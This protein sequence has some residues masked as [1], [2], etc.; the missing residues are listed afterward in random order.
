MAITA[1]PLVISGVVDMVVDVV[2]VVVHF[3]ERAPL[4][5]ALSE[6]LCSASAF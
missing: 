1:Y 4:A 5:E 6:G 2:A 3:G